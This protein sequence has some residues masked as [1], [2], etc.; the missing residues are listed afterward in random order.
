[1]VF[2]DQLQLLSTFDSGSGFIFS[3]TTLWELVNG[4]RDLD[5]SPKTRSNET[6][7]NGVQGR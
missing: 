2:S 6:G 4:P 7:S 5:L 3:T 1:M